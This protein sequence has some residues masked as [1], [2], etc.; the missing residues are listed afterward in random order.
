LSQVV[1]N[2]V[3]RKSFLLSLK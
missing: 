1:T 3:V 2:T